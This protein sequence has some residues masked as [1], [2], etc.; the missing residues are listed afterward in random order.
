MKIV[1]ELLVYKKGVRQKIVPIFPINMAAWGTDV[2]Q[3]WKGPQKTGCF[4]SSS[5]ILFGFH[6]NNNVTRKAFVSLTS[7]KSIKLN[8]QTFPAGF[9]INSKIKSSKDFSLWQ[10]RNYTVD[11][12]CHYHHHSNHNQHPVLIYF[13]DYASISEISRITNCFIT[14]NK[15]VCLFGKWNVTSKQKGN[16]FRN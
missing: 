11:E 14:S 6:Y 13:K 7:N 4:H 15:N 1:N 2:T 8:E 3:I 12:T 5:Y 16:A 9:W 10:I